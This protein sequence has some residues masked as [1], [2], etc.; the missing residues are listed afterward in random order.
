M[1]RNNSG[2]AS[3]AVKRTAIQK[4]NVHKTNAV[5]AVKR[6]AKAVSSVARPAKPARTSGGGGY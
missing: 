2:R 6:G 4:S 3:P 1:A 5:N